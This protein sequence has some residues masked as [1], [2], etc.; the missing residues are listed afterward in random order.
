VICGLSCCRGGQ[1]WA[2]GYVL[3]ANCMA[4]GESNST[5]RLFSRTI[6]SCGQIA[7][8]REGCRHITTWRSS[9]V[10]ASTC[11]RRQ[12]NKGPRVRH[13]SRRVRAS[14]GD[15]GL[16]EPPNNAPSSLARSRCCELIPA[17]RGKISALRFF[18][19]CETTCSWGGQAR[20]QSAFK[21]T[22]GVIFSTETTLR[23]MGHAGQR[24][25]RQ[26]SARRLSSPD[27]I[28]FLIMSS[29]LIDRTSRESS[30][31]T[32]PVYNG[33]RGCFEA[34][35][36]TPWLVCTNATL[37]GCRKIIRSRHS[38]GGYSAL[39]VADGEQGS[40]LDGRVPMRGGDK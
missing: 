25:D 15:C 32:P 5:A 17:N 37:C 29:S 4:M 10:L 33:I 8:T 30:S 9:T 40:D 18:V 35:S 22:R 26:C 2:R 7:A 11:R 34:R 24:S 14:A 31:P 21:Q 19:H 1:L 16:S 38:P 28:A 3:T 13:R 6:N 36:D 39:A 27:S 23:W 20:D 12:A